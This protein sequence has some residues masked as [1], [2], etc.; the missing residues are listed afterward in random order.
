M[1][2]GIDIDDTMTDSTKTVRKYLIKYDSYY[3]N[4]HKLI[5]GLNDIIRGTLIDDEIK[6][7]YRDHSREIGNEIE[8]RDNVKEV[9]DKLRKDG[10][11]III[12]TARSDNFYTDAHKFCEEYLK[13]K[14]INYDKLITHQMYKIE[15]CKNE[16]IDLMI[17]DA[18]D[19]VEDLQEEGINS[20]LFTSDLNKDRETKVKRVYTWNE[21]Y[22]YIKEIA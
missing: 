8:L 22:D 14:N 16:K 6:A 20:I 1:R 2:I 3:S 11:E 21:L 18:I 5:N 7:F 15:T 9:I 19:T 13:E 17:D 12:V 4:N 10:H